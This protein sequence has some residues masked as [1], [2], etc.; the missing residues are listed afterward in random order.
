ML[1]LKK[2]HR[3]GAEFAEIVFYFPLRVL[4]VSAVRYLNSSIDLEAS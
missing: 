2:Y 3:R 4:S 1:T